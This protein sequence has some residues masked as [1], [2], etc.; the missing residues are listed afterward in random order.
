METPQRV[1]CGLNKTKI[2]SVLT[3]RGADVSFGLRARRLW[4]RASASSEIF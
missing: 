1:Q 2:H 4:V 3:L